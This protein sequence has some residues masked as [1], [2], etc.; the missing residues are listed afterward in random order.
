MFLWNRNNPVFPVV[1]F[2]LLSGCVSTTAGVL[3][4]APEPPQRVFFATD[5]NL[6]PEKKPGGRFGSGKGEIRYGV[7]T[8]SFPP[9]HSIGELE[10]PI[11]SDDHKEHILLTDVALNDY[12]EYSGELSRHV[13]RTAD[14][15]ML[16]YVHGFNISFEKA[17]RRMAQIVRDLEFNGCPVFYSW[18]SGGTVSRYSGDEVS[19]R[20]SQRNLKRFL[21][22]VAS[23]SGAQS[24]FLIA[25][26]MGCRALTGAFLDVIAEQPHLK[27]RFRALLL[28]APDIDAEVFRRDMSGRLVQ[29]G[30]HIVI[31]TSKR[32]RALKLSKRMHGSARLG[33]VDRIPVIIPGIETIDATNVDTS[34]LGQ[35]YFNGSRSVLSDVY[36]IINKGLPAEERFSLEAVETT[37]GL[38]WKFKE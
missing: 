13:D 6:N 7:A 10:S 18:P 31:Y 26:S 32:D 11:L 33:D 28:S 20:W 27:P 24:I 19:V 29:T 38:Y 17:A 22:D 2:L 36:Y 9:D 25:H 30:A 16:V 23:T 4:V 15:S 35:S 37:H 34:F 12:R 3:E 14:K 5:R 8:V 21:G 1:L